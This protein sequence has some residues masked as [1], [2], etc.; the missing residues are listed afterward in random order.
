MKKNV[1]LLEGPIFGALCKLA[2]PIMGTS[3][4]QMAYNMVDMIWIGRIGSGAVAAVGS[5]GMY[6]WLANGFATLARMGGQVKVAHSLG[7]G[8]KDEAACYAKNALQF[9][10]ILGALY[11]VVMAVFKG[12]L[13]SFFHLNSPEVIADAELYLTIACAMTFVSFANTILTGIFTA[14]GNSQT[15]FLANT[16]GLIVNM[17]LDPLLIFGVGPLPKLGVAGAALATVIAQV[18]VTIMFIF[19]VR[20]DTIVFDK[21]HLFSKIQF[22]YVKTIV[23][24]SLPI[25]ILNMFFTG[26]SMVMARI[27]AGWG[28]AAVAVQKV[29]SQIESISWMAAEGFSAAMNS[30]LGQNYGAGNMKRVKRGYKTGIAIAAVWGL[31]TTAVLTLFP[32]PIFRIFITEAEVIPMGVEYLRILGVCQLFMCVEIM[33]SGS[34]S[35]LGKTLPPAIE[36]ISLTAARVPL[37]LILSSTAL[38]LCG[39]WWSLSI[40]SIIKGIV[41]FTWFIIVLKRLGKD[42]IKNSLA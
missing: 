17:V 34:F 4:L 29:G 2:I 24:I 37:A 5:A 39:V 38:G 18:S 21:V 35:G 1:N 14:M 12:T 41:L 8:E 11:A 33:T 22:N 27:V 15:P 19:A 28:D 3:L 40:S 25:S 26:I 36:G 20:K 6:M 16:V 23:K 32:G 13:I 30:F 7:A 31:F 9:G 10:I 42:K